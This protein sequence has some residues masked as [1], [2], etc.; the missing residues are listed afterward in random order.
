[1]QSYITMKKRNIL[2]AL[3]TFFITGTFDAN[4]QEI[5]LKNKS[6]ASLIEKKREYNKHHGTGYRIQLYYGDEKT[7]KN[8]EDRFK[9]EFPSIY[10][11]LDYKKPYWNIQVGNYKTKLQADRALN[12][13][14][15]KFNGAIVVPL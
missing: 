7:T 3:I 11:K 2:L 13:I 12:E 6:I 5:K 1:M 15:E 4:A 10:T 8:L 14:R 9:K